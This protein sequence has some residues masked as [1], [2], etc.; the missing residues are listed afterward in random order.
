MA[1][2]KKEEVKAPKFDKQKF[3][4]RKLKSLNNMSDRAKARD[5]ADRLLNK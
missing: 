2:E 1:E 3:I 4:E 5:L